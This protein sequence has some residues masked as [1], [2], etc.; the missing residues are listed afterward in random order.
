[1]TQ[2]TRSWLAPDWIPSLVLADEFF[3]RPKVNLVRAY[4]LIGLALVLECS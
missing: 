2:A 1:M 3:D 4:I